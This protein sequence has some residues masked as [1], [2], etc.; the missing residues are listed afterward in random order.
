M[1][2]LSCDDLILDTLVESILSTAGD[3]LP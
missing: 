3:S 2:S 1:G